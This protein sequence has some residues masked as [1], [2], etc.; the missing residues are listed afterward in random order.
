M[1]YGGKNMGFGIRKA[2]ISFLKA[3]YLVYWALEATF[4]RGI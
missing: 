3:L 2:D 1:Q 4:K